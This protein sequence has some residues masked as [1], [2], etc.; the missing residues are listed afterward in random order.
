MD[1]LIARQGLLHDRLVKISSEWA[2]RDPIER[3]GRAYYATI[4]GLG[5]TPP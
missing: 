2:A 1:G 5:S 3:R 4:G